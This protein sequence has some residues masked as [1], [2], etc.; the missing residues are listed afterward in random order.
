MGGGYLNPLR[1]R[2]GKLQAVFRTPGEDL[3]A[4]EADEHFAGVVDGGGG[5][6]LEQDRAPAQPGVYKLAC[7]LADH[8][9][10][11]MRATLRV[12]HS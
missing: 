9:A 8:A 12:R 6:V 4:E 2:S 3:G 5:Q 11:G 1:G 10:L 7:S